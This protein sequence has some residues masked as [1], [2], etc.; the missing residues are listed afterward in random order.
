LIFT[1]TDLVGITYMQE[2]ELPYK[3]QTAGFE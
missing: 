1:T 3:C 2:C